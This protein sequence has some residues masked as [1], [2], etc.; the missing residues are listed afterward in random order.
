MDDFSDKLAVITGGA[1]GMGRE[2][3]RQLAAEGCDV[4]ICDLSAEDMANTAAQIREESVHVRVTTHVADYSPGW[5]GWR[6][7]HDEILAALFPAAT[8][9]PSGE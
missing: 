7:Q 4:A 2:L 1:N 9:D 3:A 6:G 8:D 5:A